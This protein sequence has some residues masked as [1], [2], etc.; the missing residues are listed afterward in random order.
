MMH[1]DFVSIVRDIAIRVVTS[2]SAGSRVGSI[3]MS[4]KMLWDARVT[5]MLRCP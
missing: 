3:Q 2:K 5:M 1:D 4:W